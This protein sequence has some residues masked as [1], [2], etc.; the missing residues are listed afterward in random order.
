VQE[1]LLD[2]LV[3]QSKKNTMTLTNR[4]L[5]LTPL[6]LYLIQ[7][8]QPNIINA[9]LQHVVHSSVGLWMLS[10]LEQPLPANKKE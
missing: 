2:I 10:V 5:H 7:D 6:Y 1:R 4:F 8:A 3:I 9:F